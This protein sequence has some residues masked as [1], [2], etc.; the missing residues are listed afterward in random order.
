MRFKHGVTVPVKKRGTKRQPPPVVT[1]TKAVYRYK[2]KDVRKRR[3]LLK[4]KLDFLRKEKVDLVR[5]FRIV[6][7]LYKEAVTLGI[8]PSKNPLD[9]IEVNLRI[10]KVVNS[11]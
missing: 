2:S 11:V 3:D 5:N 1:K 7:A 6:E 9:G 8:I 4:F 10:A